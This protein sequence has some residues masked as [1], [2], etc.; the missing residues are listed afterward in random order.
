MSRRDAVDVAVVGGGVVGAAAALAFARDGWSVALVESREPAPWSAEAPDLRVYALA[1]DAM[2]VLDT[3]DVGESVRHAR[4]PAYRRMEVWDA[5]GGGALSFDADRFARRELGWIVENGL[6]VDRLW[7]AV[8]RESIA[9]H[10]PAGV[11]ALE[12]DDAHAS[13]RLDDGRR[14]AARLVVAAD[15][16][17]STLRALAGIDAPTHDYAQGGLVAYVDTERALH[18]TCYQRF[19]PTGPLAFL[20]VDAHR[21]SIVWTLPTEEAARLRALDDDAFAIA[22]GDASGGRLGKVRPASARVVVPLRRRLASTCHAG[23][24]VLVGDAAH[25]V[26]PLAGQGVNLGLRDVAA[27]R[28]ALPRPG[29]GADPAAARLARWA[30]ERRSAT[31]RAAYSFEAIN[32]LFSNDAVAPTLLRGIALGLAGRLPPLQHAL[33]REA[34]GL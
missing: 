19:L 9:L 24:L 1:P 29:R 31:A 15:G 28:A 18:A 3:L 32:R 20:P 6:L 7:V 30:R 22:L 16:A 25:A 13:L 8:R 5:A 27:L 11:E 26:H 2:A 14:L 23:R 10:V 4:A 17:N 33:W 21:A 12:Q 34:A